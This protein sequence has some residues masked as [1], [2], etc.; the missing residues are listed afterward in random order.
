MRLEREWEGGASTWRAEAAGGRGWWFPPS[1][2]VCQAPDSVEEGEVGAE[3][4]ELRAGDVSCRW[5]ANR[6]MVSSVVEPNE[7]AACVVPRGSGREEGREEGGRCNGCRET[8]MS[9]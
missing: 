6:A 8:E 9:H 7:H 4:A 1:L 5:A 2:P 3:M